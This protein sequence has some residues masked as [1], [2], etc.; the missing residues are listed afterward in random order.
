MIR[1]RYNGPM[2]LDRLLANSGYGSRTE[3]K[4]LVKD[5]C[6][7][8]HGTVV[9]DAGLDV[10]DE[11]RPEIGIQGQPARIRRFHYLMMDKP[12]GYITAMDDPKHRTIADLI[13]TSYRQADLF[14]VGRLDFD[15][16]GLLLLTN[17][18]VLGHRLASPKY[19]VDKT[20][21]VT[22]EGNPFHEDRDPALFDAGLI[23]EDG[24]VCRPAA[25]RIIRPDYAL[26][27]IHEGKY[28][29]VKRMMGAT[30]RKVTALRRLTLGPVSLDEA[31]G[32]GQVRELTEDEINALYEAV[33]LQ[34]PV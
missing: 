33:D 28:H 20:Y 11:D 29:Q 23:L 24:L 15:T 5:G 13:P 16:T 21:A 18:G 7:T 14:P 22:I 3:I 26:L 27:T 4:R 19:G 34:R 12:H 2:R 9:R 30:G 1:I 31:I 10:R 32:S 17:D 25:I 6:V 8:L